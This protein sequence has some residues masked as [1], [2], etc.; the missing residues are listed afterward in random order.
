[1]IFDVKMEGSVSGGPGILNLTG[2][3]PHKIVDTDETMATF[4]EQYLGEGVAFPTFLIAIEE[5]LVKKILKKGKFPRMYDSTRLS[6]VKYRVITKM[7]VKT[8]AH[9]LCMLRLLPF[10]VSG[11]VQEC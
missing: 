7:E 11:A 3:L 2:Y 5:K 10:S 9:T 4:Q 6:N 1:M 8:P